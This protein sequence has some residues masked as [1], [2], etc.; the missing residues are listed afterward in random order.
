LGAYYLFVLII[1]LIFLLFLVF[2]RKAF[3]GLTGRVIILLMLWAF[4]AS[5]LFPGIVSFLSPAPALMAVSFLAVAGGYI[6]YSRAAETKE[7]GEGAAAGHT[8]L[9]R[10]LQ[11]A[12]G[13]GASGQ[14][15]A[16]SPVC[17]VQTGVSPLQPAGVTAGGHASDSCKNS[18][19]VS[20]REGEEISGE[21]SFSG[22][23]PEKAEPARSAERQR[24]REGRPPLSEEGGE[25]FPEDTASTETSPKREGKE[26]LLLP[27]GDRPLNT[28]VNSAY[29]AKEKDELTLATELFSEVLSRT[30]DINLKGMALTEL[31][32]LYRDQGRYLEA[33]DMIGEFLAG[34]SSSLEP[35]LSRY[36]RQMFAYMQTVDEL[37]KKAKSPGL[38]FPQVPHLIKMSA[39][40]VLKE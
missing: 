14:V 24:E 30:D 8:G 16:Q 36:Y 9:E 19:H 1:T 12:G 21:V 13:P 6:I 40:K 20:V 32:F 27:R 29:Q 23:I 5:S 28:L 15:E 34:H 39:E 38:P 37:L 35:T 4:I 2:F 7:T 18:V 17:G 3:V 31:I 26:V 33:A 11:V 25:T 10:D 22:P